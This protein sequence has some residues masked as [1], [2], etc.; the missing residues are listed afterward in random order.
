MARKFLTVFN[1]SLSSWFYIHYERHFLSWISTG[2]LGKFD[3][4]KELIEIRSSPQKLSLHDLRTLLFVAKYR[5]KVKDVCN[6][7]KFTAKVIWNLREIS[8]KVS[9]LS[10]TTPGHRRCLGEDLLE[11]VYLGKPISLWYQA[12]RAPFNRVQYAWQLAP[13]SAWWRP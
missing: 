12:D 2:C 1:S 4:V 7:W 13:S 10:E 11:A 9:D 5:H 6:G 8:I 3:N